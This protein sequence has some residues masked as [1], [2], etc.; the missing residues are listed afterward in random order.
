MFRG[1]AG[2]GTL[3]GMSNH[4]FGSAVTSAFLFLFLGG[5]A[6]AAALSPGSVA[7]AGSCPICTSSAECTSFDDGGVAFCVRHAGPVGCGAELTLCCPGQGC[8][9]FSGRPSC[10][11]DTCTVIEDLVDGGPGATDGG[12]G[13][14]DGGPASTDA[15]PSPGDGGPDGTDGGPSTSDAGM[16]GMDAGGTTP[17]VTTTPAC[18][19]RFGARTSPAGGLAALAMVVSL[20]AVRLRRS[21]A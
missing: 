5:F 18:G 3:P 14:T 15:G 17:P 16:V 11:G 13:G 1:E 10:E 19:C 20:V 2:G 6:A 21:R 7:R 4:R 9:T 12:P 8:N